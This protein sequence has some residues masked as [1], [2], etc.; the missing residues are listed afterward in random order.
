ME[1]GIEFDT[2]RLIK[3]DKGLKSPAQRVPPKGIVAWVIR[4]KIAADEKVAKKVL[5][6]FI[7][8][9]FLIAVVIYYF[10]IL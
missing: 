1:S 5:Y 6:K 10:F 7:A 9:N 2:D 3:T 4:K 8:V